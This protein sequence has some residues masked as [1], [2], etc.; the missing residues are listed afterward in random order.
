[1]VNKF[2][3][4]SEID[5]SV[6]STKALVNLYPYSTLS[7]QPPHTQSLFKFSGLLLVLQPHVLMSPLRHERPI[8]CKT[9]A[10]DIALTKAASL[11]ANKLN[12]D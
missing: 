4:S 3:L 8:A 5:F 6:I 1:M 2:C 11:L 7:P 10:A 12:I 9:P